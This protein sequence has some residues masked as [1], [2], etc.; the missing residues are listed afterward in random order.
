MENQKYNGWTNYETWR[1][2]LEIFDGYDPDGDPVD[3]DQLK[4]FAE[5]LVEMEC[6]N[7]QGLAYSYAM[8]FLQAVDWYEIAR[9]INENHEL[10]E[11]ECDD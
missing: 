4:D 3:G 11:F 10:G 2:N 1:V 6:E 8:A 5:D 7:T 9:A